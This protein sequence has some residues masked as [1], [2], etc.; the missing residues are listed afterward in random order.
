[1][2]LVVG[3][4][5]LATYIYTYK[6]AFDKTTFWVRVGIRKWM[7]SMKTQHKLSLQPL[8]SLYKL[9][10]LGKYNYMIWLE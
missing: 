6:S 2:G 4:L 10:Y 8:K 3:T 7:C 9:A 5:D 1:M